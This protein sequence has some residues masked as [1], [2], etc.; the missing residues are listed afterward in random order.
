MKLQLLMKKREDFQD[1]LA[2][3]ETRKNLSSESVSLQD[4]MKSEGL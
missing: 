1:F 4:M 3:T 2:G